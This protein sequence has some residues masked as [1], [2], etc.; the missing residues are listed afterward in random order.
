MRRTFG[1]LLVGLLFATL[2]GLVVFT[3]AGRID[4]P[5][6]WAILIVQAISMSAIALTLA[7]ELVQERLHPGAEGRVHDHHR[8][9]VTPLIFASWI[10][11]GLDLG[12]F[13][14][15]DTIPNGMRIAGI[16]GYAL[17]MILTY[18]AMHTNR[19]YSSVIRLQRDRGHE[20][21]T[22]GPYARIRHPGYAATI[23][24]ILCGTFALGS[25]VALMPAIGV[26]LL[27]LRRTIS[28]DKMLRRDL[29]GY[30]DYATRVRCRLVPG[31][32]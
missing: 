6:V 15:S 9:F 25:W 3:A 5:Y 11:A 22:T 24:A 29:E 32:W 2:T 7:P 28:E 14:W 20:P 4:L 16:V 21:I 18:W 30:A 27:F 10:L 19:F 23:I 17:A 1:P 8:A 12:R 26:V 31:V 13:H